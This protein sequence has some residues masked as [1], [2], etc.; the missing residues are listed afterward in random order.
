V[1][2]EVAHE[3]LGHRGQRRTLSLGLSAGFTMLGVLVPGTG[4][5]D[6]L[7]TPLVVRAYTREQEM[8]ADRKAVELLRS[9]GYDAPPPGPRRS[10]EPGGGRQRLGAER[11]ARHRAHARGPPDRHR[12]GGARPQPH[13]RPRPL[14]G[15]DSP[16]AGVPS[17]IRAARDVEVAG[18]ASGRRIERACDSGH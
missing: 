5:L 1:A 11:L 8:A 15:W 13:R 12:P 16:R 7:V 6:L 17:Q 14:A 2:H 4:L 10:P 9:I 3:L 18:G